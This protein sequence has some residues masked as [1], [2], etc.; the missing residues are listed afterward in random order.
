MHANRFQIFQSILTAMLIVLLLLSFG[1]HREVPTVNA[2]EPQAAAA[3]AVPG[4]P[5]Y[6]MI[7]ATAFIPEQST[8]TYRVFWGE[9]SVPTSSP[10]PIVSFNAAVY[11]PQGATLTGMTMFYHDTIV[12][13]KYLGVDLM[14][15][16]L[17]SLNSG[18]NVGL[19]IYS[20]LFSQTGFGLYASDTT[21]DPTRAEID[22]SQY[23]YWLKLYIYA[24]SSYLQLQAVRID[25][26]YTAAL[27]LIQR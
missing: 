4:G 11:L 3:A 7:P 24:A 22:N 10:I 15:K 1:F 13:T 9:L 20:E 16:P 21:P 14:R 19:S 6:V 17:P 18:E 25:F 12:D 5:G 2:A 23:S 26:T 8:D 27:P